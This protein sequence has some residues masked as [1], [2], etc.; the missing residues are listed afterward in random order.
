MIVEGTLCFCGPAGGALADLWFFL[1][2]RQDT[3]KARRAQRNYGS[4]DPPMYFE[5]HVWEAHETRK[6]RF[7]KTEAH[8]RRYLVPADC[9]LERL[10]QTMGQIVRD[11]AAA[12]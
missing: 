1:A 6:W 4:P 12:L 5:R 2:S 9:A 3:C 10:A 8:A 11:E 7:L